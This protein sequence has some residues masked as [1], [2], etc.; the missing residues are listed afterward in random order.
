MRTTCREL[1]SFLR[2]HADE[3]REETCQR[4]KILFIDAI[5][6]AGGDGGGEAEVRE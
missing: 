1:D 4:E 2:G 5:R 6:R 3:L